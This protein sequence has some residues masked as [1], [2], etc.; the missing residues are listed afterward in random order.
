MQIVDGIASNDLRQ[1][2]ELISTTIDFQQS[3]E[4]RRICV[5]PNVD[6]ELDEL[7]RNYDG[8]EHFLNQV[9][10]HLLREIPEWAHPYVK[11][12]IFYPQIGFL[13]VVSLDP[14][15]GRGKYEGEGHADDLWESQ[16]VTNGN[17]YYKNRHMKELD[18]EYG[19]LYCMIV[20]KLSCVCVLSS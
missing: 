9:A 6:V 2:G 12:C 4:A 15:T 1:V 14:E 3:K 18:T 13:T 7:K 19:D 10:I 11:N 20:G 8:L 16:F 5:L 17:I